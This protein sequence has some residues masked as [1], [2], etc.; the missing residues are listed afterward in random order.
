MIGETTPTYGKIDEYNES[1]D[2]RYYIE[3]LNHFF[4]AN[5]ITDDAKQRSIFLVSVSAKSYKL[6]RSLVVAEDLKEKSYIDM[7]K[8]VQEKYKPKPSIIVERFKF[9]TLCLQQVETISV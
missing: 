2:L 6:I 7:V 9:N 4:E 1:E 5:E 8:L 3:R